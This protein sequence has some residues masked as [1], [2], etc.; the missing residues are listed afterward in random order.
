LTVYSI[1]MKPLNILHVASHNVIQAGGAIQMM[2]LARGLKEGGHHVVCAF[3]IRRDDEIPGRGT[4]AP[5]QEDG[6]ET[7]S[8]PMQ[9]LQKYGGMLRL[10]KLLSARRF[11]VVHAHRFR[12]LRF[13]CSAT[14]GM[15]L[16][17]LI[18]DRKNSYPIPRSWARVYGRD[19]VDR[20]IVNAE[21]IR[22]LL[23]Q[24]G[25]VDARKIELVY[26][27][28]D[29]KSFH[30]QVDGTAIRRELGIAERV[31]VFGM[32]ANFAAKKSHDVFFAAAMK[33]LEEAP[34]VIFLLVGGG[35]RGRYEALAK[36][37]GHDKN[38]IFTG[39]RS[40]IPLVI[41]GLD[42][43]LISSGKGEGL[44]GS[45]VESMA[46]A[47]PVISTDVGANAEFVRQKDTGLLVAPGSPGQL[48]E[49]MLYLLRNRAEAL[50]MGQRAYTFAKDRVDNEQRTRRMEQI[51]YAILQEK[52]LATD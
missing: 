51:Y 29:L 32:I 45:L 35:D 4:F 42:F 24:T 17:A 8:F 14:L 3:N 31:P 20:I 41:A 23:I 50:A 37:R 11:D 40:D 19:A 15:K 16:P 44:T 21:A 47:K 30:P 25:R 18:G 6:I 27:G 46:M 13:I 49:A 39:F 7:L 33:V 28:V 2:R 26:N 43:S 38:F 22:D 12:A 52:G 48:A 10:R 9:R 1:P 36:D 5:L 34:E